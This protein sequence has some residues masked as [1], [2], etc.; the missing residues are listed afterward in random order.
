MRERERER[1][2]SNLRSE[3]KQGRERRKSIASLRLRLNCSSDAIALQQG[4][5]GFGALIERESEGAGE[6]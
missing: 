2:L 1:I 6:E 5:S 3:R 4:G